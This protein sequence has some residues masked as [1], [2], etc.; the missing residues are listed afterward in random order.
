M[1]KFIKDIFRKGKS[2]PEQVIAPPASDPQI[3][4]A[5][6]PSPAGIIPMGNV[7]W[8]TGEITIKVPGL[9]LAALEDSNSMDPLFD[10]GHLLIETT[11]FN[12]DELVV[13]DIVSYHAGSGSYIVHRIESIEEDEN[14]RLFRFL[15]DNNV[16][17]R[18]PYLVRA[19]HLRALVVGIIYTKD[20]Y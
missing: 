14:G 9:T 16:G 2:N 20:N 4:G 11:E 15:G 19:E 12:P 13:G 10:R 1:C 6:K 8:K 7:S 3:P 5:E 18:D 17:R